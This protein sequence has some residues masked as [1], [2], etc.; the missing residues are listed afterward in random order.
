[1]VAQVTA[2]TTVYVHSVTLDGSAIAGRDGRESHVT[3]PWKLHVR[4]TLIMTKVSDFPL[5]LLGYILVSKEMRSRI[6]P[7]KLLNY[8]RL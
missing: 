3:S 4:I 1:M 2:V 8:F 7:A 6:I 5:V